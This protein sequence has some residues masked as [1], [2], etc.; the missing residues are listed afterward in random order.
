LSR[1]QDGPSVDERSRAI[2]DQDDTCVPGRK[3]GKVCPGVAVVRTR[4]PCRVYGEDVSCWYVLHT[5][6]L[7]SP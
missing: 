7:D 6:G 1:M 5:R 2:D 4:S 3:L